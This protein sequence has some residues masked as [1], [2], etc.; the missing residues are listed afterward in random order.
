MNILGCL[1]VPTAGRYLLDGVDV[2]TLDE[3]RAGRRAQP[4]DRLRLPELQPRP[5][6]DGAGQRRAAAGLR[7]ASKRASAARARSA[8]LERGRARRPRRST[9]PSELSGGQQQRVAIARALVT[10]PALI[11]ADEPTG[12]L[13]SALDRRGPRIFDRLNA[14]GRTVVMITHEDEVAAHAGGSIRL[15]DG[16][17]VDDAASADGADSRATAGGARM[18]PRAL[19][20]ALRGIGANKLRSALT[21]LGILIGV[22]VGD[23]PGRGR[24]RLRRRPSQTIETLGTEHPH[25][26]RAAASASARRRRRRSTP[27]A[28]PITDADVDGARR[29]T[30]R[31]P[32]SRRV[33]ARSS[34]LS[35]TATYNGASTRRATFVGTTPIVRRG[36][37]TTTSRRARS[38]PT[39]DVDD[40]AA[41]RRARPRPSPTNLFGGRGPGRPDGQGQ[42][43]PFTVVGVLAP[44]APTAPGPRRHRHRAAHDGRRTR[45]PAPAA[46]SQI[47]VQA[48]LERH[49]DAG[50]EPRSRPSSTRATRASTTRDLPRPQPGLAARR[51]RRDATDVHRAARPR[52]PRSR[53]SSAASAS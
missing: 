52:S 29:T 51:R 32:T 1:D 25:R 7:R 18:T 30:T 4:Q 17:I 39:T 20:I 41:R 38:S 23:R 28:A 33:V 6:H 50:A 5:A 11:L 2:A 34:T 10:D 14:E 53:C 36:A 48:T 46:L 35:A 21:M 43:R 42:R 40:H 26:H 44:R 47:V 12:N 16:A 3:R 15:R 8:A 22:A 13:D 49:V 19:R 45:S 24:Q 9:C 27:A 31:R 37:R